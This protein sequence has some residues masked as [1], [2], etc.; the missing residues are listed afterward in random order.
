[1]SC[2]HNKA[3]YR[4]IHYDGGCCC[5]ANPPCSYCTDQELYC[6]DCDTVIE[7]YQP[8][9]SPKEPSNKDQNKWKN[10]WIHKSFDE[11]FRELPNGVFGS[12]REPNDGWGMRVKGK[13]PNGMTKDEVLSRCG[14]CKYGCPHFKIFSNGVF[15][16][17]YNYD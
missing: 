6:D 8:P 2:E 15:L 4:S 17:T 16:F 1:M 10:V 14:I 12:V 3:E 11:R 13:M 5:H 9:V 7:E